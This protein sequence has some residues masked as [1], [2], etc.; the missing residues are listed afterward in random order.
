[1]QAALFQQKGALFHNHVE[2]T[3]FEQSQ[4]VS[5][6]THQTA[7]RVGHFRPGLWKKDML[8]ITSYVQLRTGAKSH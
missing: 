6:L 1:M 4:E 7:M 2:S 8:C 3:W 5:R